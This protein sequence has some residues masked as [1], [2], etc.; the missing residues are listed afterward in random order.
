MI[1]A[2]VAL[3]GGLMILCAAFAAGT[4]QQ[5]SVSVMGQHLECGPSIS[6]SWLV[7][8]TPDRAPAAC[9]PVIHRSRVLILTAMGAGGL[10]ALIGWTAIRERQQPARRRLTPVGA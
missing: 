4:E 10:V 1:W 2:K 5:R 3:A 6:A 7:S 8:G 9:S